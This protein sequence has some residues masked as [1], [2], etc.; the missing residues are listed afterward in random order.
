MVRRF[1]PK[2]TEELIRWYE[3]YISPLALIA[4]F[5][6][7]NYILLRRVD[8]WTSNLLLFSYLAISGLGIVLI[9]LIQTGRL[10]NPIFVKSAPF[11]P[12]VAQFAFGGLFS[13]YVSL[14]GRSAAYSTSWIFVIALAL[15]LLGNERFTRFYSRFTF[16]VGIFFTV[17]FSFLIFY[18]P[19]I[20]GNIGPYIFVASG[21]A[22]LIIM[23]AFIRFLAF[24][25]PEHVKMHRMHIIRSIAIIFVTFNILYFSN[26]IPPLPLALKDAGVYHDIV[27]EGD[28]YVLTAEP[29]PWY[30]SYLRYN[31]VYHRTAGETVF[32]YSAVFAPSK[33]STT[34]LHEWEYYDDKTNAWVRNG[35]FGFPLVGGRDGGYR[36]YSLREN[37]TAGKWRVNVKTGNGLIIGRIS[38]TVVDVPTPVKTVLKQA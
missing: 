25:M 20:L 33:F 21:I 12:V 26:A 5:L 23:S 11:L 7:D 37:V 8:L 35:T 22:S 15:L 32:V 34:V 29:V 16:Q 19:I 17:L 28:A 1:L 10:Q 30:E 13:G 18:L 14:Y 24:L 31:T 6:A 2:S 4:G 9:N 27:K 3:R 36:G 38:F